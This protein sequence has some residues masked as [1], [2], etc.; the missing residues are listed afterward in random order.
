MARVTF[1]NAIVSGKVGGTVYA[2]NKGGSYMRIL[3][4]PTN[5]KSVA[6]VNAR[7]N[8]GGGSNLYRACTA[9]QRAAYNTFAST[10][11]N[12]LKGRPG[13][14]Y[15]GQQAAN[16]LNI[17]SIS[18][19]LLIRTGTIKLNTVAVTATFGTFAGV[20]NPPAYR[21]AGQIQTSTHG[22][23]NLS[24]SAGSVTTAGAATFEITADSNIAAAP[25]FSNVGQTEFVGFSLYMSNPFGPGQSFVTNK[26]FKFLGSTGPILTA[27]A[28][29]V[30]PS[31]LIEFA[32]TDTKLVPGSCHSWITIGNKVRL[33]VVMESQS[34]QQVDLG[35]VDFTVVA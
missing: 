11:F 29:V 2:H 28:T 13:V 24:M 3:R 21:L 34:G 19:D 9:A 30:T 33:T 26:F 17:A 8:F 32:F 12:P 16:A 14:I 1:M 22:P 5:P 23:L 15:S 7:N 20:V 4:R 6:Q 31:P 27:T 18:A 25:I 35:S 10:L